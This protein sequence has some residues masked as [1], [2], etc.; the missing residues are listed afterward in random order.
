LDVAAACLA[1]GEG[2][3][4]DEVHHD[5]QGDD[6]DD[7][8][9][10]DYSGLEQNMHYPVSSI[11]IQEK[12]TQPKK[13]HTFASLLQLMENPRGEDGKHLTG[14]GTPATRG[15]ILQKLV[16][17]KYVLLKG[18]NILIS[19]EGRFLMENVLK[20][21]SLASFVSVPETTNW[22]EQMHSD[23]AAFLEGIKGF[24]RE[25]VKNTSFDAFQIEKKS[26]GECPF[27]KGPVYEGKKNFYC[28]NY[29]GEDPCK[30]VVWKEIWGAAVSPSDVQ[31]LLSGKQT[32]A[33]KCIGKADKEFK[34]AFVLVKGKVEFRFE[35][36]KK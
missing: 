20:N 30:F 28:G 21:E 23:T 35:D 36:K 1:V 4:E 17:R 9:P 33:K 3:A 6:A 16:D 19:E 22:E 8:K 13:H 7:E 34:A 10:E 24:V 11:E 15:A 14:L 2:G 32:K 27:C 26:L 25:A 29:K 18:K 5:R 31:L 12:K